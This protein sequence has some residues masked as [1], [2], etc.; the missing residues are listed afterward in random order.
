MTRHVLGSDIVAVCTIDTPFGGRACVVLLSCCS[1]L[2][3]C[4]RTSSS[5][6]FTFAAS[7]SNSVAEGRHAGGGWTRCAKAA[8]S[9]F[10]CSKRWRTQLTTTRPTRNK[11]GM[12]TRVDRRSWTTF[13][14]TVKATHRR[15]EIYPTLGAGDPRKGFR[16]TTWRT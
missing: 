3:R 10:A 9:V 7:T 2:T 1:I 14:I 8:S 16:Q 4:F 6:S 13:Q 5:L 15:K 12:P 11:Y